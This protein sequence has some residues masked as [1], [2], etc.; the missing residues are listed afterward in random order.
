L[1][2]T[3]VEVGKSFLPIIVK[4]KLQIINK[5]AII[6]VALVKKLPA[7]L[8]NMK[9]SWETPIPR[10][11]PSDFWNN[12]RIIKIIANIIF[13]VRRIFSME[14]TYNNFLLYQ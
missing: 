6:A 5:V 4:L 9:L 8:E 14:V 2:I 12:I 10:A 1:S 7:V 3:E 11:P 13:N